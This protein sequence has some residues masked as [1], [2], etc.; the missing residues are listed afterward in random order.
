MSMADQKTPEELAAEAEAKARA[1]AEAKAKAPKAK[2]APAEDTIT[3]HFEGAPYTGTLNIDAEELAVDEGT[4]KV[5]S[6][7]V[8]AARQAGFK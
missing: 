6:R 3:L 7:L 1:E 2:V 8:A 5:P 4:V